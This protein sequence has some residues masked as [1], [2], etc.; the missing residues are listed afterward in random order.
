MSQK[1]RQLSEY[2]IV[3]ELGEKVCMRIAQEVIAGLDDMSDALFSGDDSGLET[4]WEEICVQQ[5][6]EESTYWSTYDQM[7]RDFADGVVASL[8]PFELDAAWLI[9]DEGCDW[10]CEDE[11]DRESYP[12]R[13]RGIVNYVIEN[14]VYEEARSSQ[15]S[16]VLNYQRRKNEGEDASEGRDEE[17]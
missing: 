10:S 2:V 11:D 1:P 15:N 8:E 13:N 14:V 17:E 7:V 12:V 5:Q 6:V 16:N 9:T 3:Q 4:I